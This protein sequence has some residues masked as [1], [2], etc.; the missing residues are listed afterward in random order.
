MLICQQVCPISNYLEGHKLSAVSTIFHRVLLLADEDDIRDV[1]LVVADLAAKW[2]DVGISLGI[3]LSD[4]DAIL[5]TNPQSP[6]DCM[7]ETLALWVKQNYNVRTTFILPHCT[8]CPLYG[9]CITDHIIH[10]DY[11]VTKLHIQSFTNSGINSLIHQ[12]YLTNPD[13]VVTCRV[14]ILKILVVV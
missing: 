2:K 7:R 3:C 11:L 13:I 12:L 4:L 5:S 8:M 9:S 14:E 6:H 10:F 1:R